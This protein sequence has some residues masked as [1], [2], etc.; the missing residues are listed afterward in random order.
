MLLIRSFD[1][2]KIP[3]SVH[4]ILNSVMLSKILILLRQFY[5][6]VLQANH[7]FIS[8]KTFLYILAIVVVTEFHF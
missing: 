8:F 6:S 1:G 3:V 7:V 2:G 4:F 5:R